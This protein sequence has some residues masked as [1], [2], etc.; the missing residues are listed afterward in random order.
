MINNVSYLVE[1][2]L[3]GLVN[4]VHAYCTVLDVITEVLQTLIRNPLIQPKWLLSGIRCLIS[5]YA[6]IGALPLNH[7]GELSNPS[8]PSCIKW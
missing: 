1:S 5:W 7:A 3:T 4:L 8:S 2:Q 6:P